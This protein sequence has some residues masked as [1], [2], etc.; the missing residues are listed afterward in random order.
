MKIDIVL[1]NKYHGTTLLENNQKLADLTRVIKS[2]K[3]KNVV[4]N[5]SNKTCLSECVR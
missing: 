5:I 3:S 1:G 4:K 2:K